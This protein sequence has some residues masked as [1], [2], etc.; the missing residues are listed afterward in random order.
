MEMFDVVVLGAGTAG[1]NIAEKLI[2]G[3]K[4]V[5]LI[6]AARVG[7]ECPYVACMPSKA[8][9]RSAHVRQLLP[10][11]EELGAA[12]APYDPHDD[13]AAYAVAVQRRDRLSEDRN[14]SKHAT[15]AEEKGITLVRGRGRVTASGVVTV[16]DRALGYRDLVVATG[17]QPIRPPIEGLET[18]PTWTSDEALSSYERPVSLLV[19]GGGAVGCELAQAF[20]GFGCAVTLV[21][22][23]PSLLSDQEPEFGRILTEALRESGVDVRLGQQVAWAEAAP[24]GATVTLDDGATITVARVLLAAGRRPTV[25]DIGLD[26][27]GIY[28]SDKGLETDEYLRVRGQLHVWAAGD[29]TGD[30]PYTHTANYQAGVVAANLLGGETTV[31][32]H[33]IPD[34]IYTA[35]EYAAVGLTLSQARAAGHDAVSAAVDLRE[36]ERGVTEGIRAGRLSLVADRRRRV[37]LG[38]AIIGPYAAE[39]IG[40]AILAVQAG[41]PLDALTRVVH[42]FPTFSEAYEVTLRQLLRQLGS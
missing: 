37:L 14:D 35:P 20:V 30:K 32:Y 33:A 2:T 27:L 28:C 16:D 10:R 19:I 26:I 1:E 13:A 38:A 17:S 29:V 11:L 4:T 36:T 22:V 15:S 3:G 23:A 21:E 5:A 25:Q 24:D 7:G 42:P 18:V 6:E 34:A 9:L 39:W 12:V 8:L 40:E 41:I 31:D